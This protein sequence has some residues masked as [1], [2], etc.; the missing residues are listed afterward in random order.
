MY[1]LGQL[2]KYMIILLL[3]DVFMLISL[4]TDKIYFVFSMIDIHK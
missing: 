4:L 2:S 1:F 3:I